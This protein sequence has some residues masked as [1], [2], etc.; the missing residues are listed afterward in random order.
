MLFKNDEGS[1]M[2]IWVFVKFEFDSLVT[3]DSKTHCFNLSA[4]ILSLAEKHDMEESE[5]LSP[6]SD[7][8]RHHQ[9][10]ET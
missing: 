3:G 4:A 10:R 8:Q 9:K 1:L 7:T 6:I 5:N 2:E